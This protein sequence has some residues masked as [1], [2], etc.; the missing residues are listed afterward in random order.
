MQTL[1]G[2][3]PTNLLETVLDEVGVALLIVDQSGQ[4]AMANRAAVDMFGGDDPTGRYLTEWR[5]AFK[6]LDRQGHEIPG[7]QSPI[8][9]VLHGEELEPQDIGLVLPDGRTRWLHGAA[10]PF[11]VMGLTG[12]FVIFGDETK[13]MELRRSMELLQRLDSVG[14]LAGAILHD[15]NNMLSV[16]SGCVALALAD[17]ALPEA[18]RTQLQNASLAL[19]KGAALARR[20]TQYS[21][22]QPINVRPVQLNTTVC[23]AL[24]LVRPLVDK[25][26]RV[27]VELEDELP[28]VEV[29]ASEMEQVIVNLILNALDAMP[30]GGELLLRT[31]V[32][33]RSP[34]SGDEMED[35]NRFALITVADTGIGIPQQFH[36]RIFEPFFSTKP[37]GQGTG[38][39]LSNAYAVVHHHGGNIEVQS[40]PGVG[41][42]FRIFLPLEAPV[43]VVRKN[44]NAA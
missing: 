40:A 11:S 20:L 5:Q 35:A 9:R 22:T 23:S 19:R 1:L 33:P 38:L 3:K 17:Q 27:K 39:G 42:K 41:S 29:D 16:S 43:K 36:A 25:R 13:Q 18:T 4:V 15:F 34:S 44:E 31:E 32:A 37:D 12:V 21:H 14:R 28:T 6:V 10:F 30:E 26:V 2:L 7:G 24:E 8:A